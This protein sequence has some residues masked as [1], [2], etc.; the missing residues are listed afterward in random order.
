MP[1][2]AVGHLPERGA[3]AERRVERMVELRDRQH[4]VERR[5]VE[6]RRSAPCATR[7][8]TSSRRRSYSLSTSSAS[9]WSGY[10]LS[11]HECPGVRGDGGTGVR[12]VSN[13]RSHAQAKPDAGAVSLVALAVP[14]PGL[15]TRPG[16]RR[17]ALARAPSARVFALIHR[18]SCEFPCLHPSMSARSR[19]L[20]RPVAGRALRHP[21]AC[22]RIA[23]LGPAAPPKRGQAAPPRSHPQLHPR[24]ARG[25]LAVARREPR[26]RARSC[27]TCS[28]TST[29][30]PSPAARPRASP[31]G[32]P[33]TRSRASAPMASQVVF[34]SDR[35]GAD[36]V[37]VLD[38]AT[39][40]GDAEV[41]RGK[42]ER[43]PLRRVVAGRPVHRG[44]QGRIPRQP[45]HALDVPRRRRQRPG[46]L[47]GTR[48]RRARH[49]AVQQ[50][51][52]AFSADGKHIW[53]TRAH[54]RVE[55]QLAVS[56]VP[57]L[58]L[59]SR[60]RRARTAVVH[61]TA[62][63]CAPRSAPMV[64]GWCTARATRRTPGSAFANW[65]PARSGGW[66]T[67]RSATRWRRAPRSTRCPA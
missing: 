47:Q 67:P 33:S 53:F 52:A 9:W 42:S 27:S 3:L 62:R 8:C 55:L 60:N 35:Q 37:H 61:A 43:V 30:C 63:R 28:A 41:T 18:D 31:R 21:P 10:S 49:G 57:D 29:R 46:A 65:P 19:C 25:H 44:Q 48:Q 11:E 34:I 59:Q 24:H 7:A 51:G 56:A 23:P 50:A 12:R 6:A 58:A 2:H 32:W 1:R 13:R 45:A 39:R 5:G 40:R 17:P 54:R 20:W 36:N 22:R 14:R 4:V 64:A 15:Q 26:R 38:L 16:C 66:P